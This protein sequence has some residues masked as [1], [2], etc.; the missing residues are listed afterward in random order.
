MVSFYD[1]FM[2]LFEK[3]FLRKARR[4]ILTKASGSVLEIGGGTG[5]NLKQYHF[6]VIDSLVITD[7]DIDKRLIKRV[8]KHDSIN[9][10]KINKTSVEDLPFPNASF[11]T[12]IF[13]LV[14]CTV[15]DVNQGL[16]EI[17]R[18]LK[19]D[20]KLLFIE[21]IHPKKKSLRTI[22]NWINPVWRKISSGCNLNRDIRSSLV[23][24]GFQIGEYQYL[25]KQI[26]VGGCA[27]K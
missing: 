5:L 4:S 22:F 25:T 23:E 9:K 3:R 7:I 18:V 1:S 15:K 13:T 16:Q 24:N 2:Y 8:Q 21:H 11:D 20:G 14:F 26:F 10:I 17:K 12:V 19:D 27:K 6:D